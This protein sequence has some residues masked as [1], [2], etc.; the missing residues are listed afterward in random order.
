MVVEGFARFNLPGIDGIPSPPTVI[1][2]NNTPR[3]AALTTLH[4]KY[5]APEKQRPDGAA[6]A[7]GIGD[8]GV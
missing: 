5:K 8:T 1:L 6:G 2:K 7:F 4:T 3:R